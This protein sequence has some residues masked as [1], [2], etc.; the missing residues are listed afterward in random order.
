MRVNKA[1]LNFTLYEE[2]KDPLA[3]KEF[4]AAKA[5]YLKSLR[6]CNFPNLTGTAI[7]IIQKAKR[8]K[9]NIGP[10]KNLSYFEILNRVGSDLVLLEGVTMLF[11]NHIKNIK[12]K[13]IALKMGNQAGEDITIELE[14]NGG[15]IYGEAFNASE[16]LKGHKMRHS[17]KIILKKIA[18]DKSS[19]RVGVIFYNADM[20]ET[21]MKQQIKTI[22]DITIYKIAC[23]IN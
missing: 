11:S 15:L 14:N 9:C 21:N 1:S 10:Y 5:L 6:E 3:K 19:N 17:E 8:D 23:L 7:E 4:L 13:R 22:D 2:F 20:E 12:P 16:S 18:E